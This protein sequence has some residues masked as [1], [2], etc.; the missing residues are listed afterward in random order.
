MK[1]RDAIKNWPNLNWSGSFASSDRIGPPN[2]ATTVIRDVIDRSDR[3]GNKIRIDAEANNRP[4]SDK[5]AVGALVFF[6]DKALFDRVFTALKSTIGK[7]LNAAGN[8]SI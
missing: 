1:I 6:A 5:Q 4:F 2:P 8:I 3:D 7:T